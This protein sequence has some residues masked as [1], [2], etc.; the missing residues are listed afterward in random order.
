MLLIPV[1]IAI[2]LACFPILSTASPAKPTKDLI[3]VIDLS[4]STPIFIAAP[5]ASAKGKENLCILAP[6]LLTELPNFFNLELAVFNE[7]FNLEASP[8]S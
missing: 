2:S 8:I 7:L 4:K 3:L 5:A 1:S 6:I